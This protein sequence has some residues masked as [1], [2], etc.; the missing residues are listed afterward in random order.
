MSRGKVRKRIN[1]GII[2]RTNVT[3]L[4]YTLEFLSKGWNGAKI[5]DLERVI[6]KLA[7][8]IQIYAPLP[9]WPHTDNNDSKQTGILCAHFTSTGSRKQALFSCWHHF[10]FEIISNVYLCFGNNSITLFFWLML[11]YFAMLLIIK[12]IKGKIWFVK[13]YFK[14][15]WMSQYG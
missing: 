11:I 12:V 1:S 5:S 9:W 14:E 15:V 7:R 3:F 6:R 4:L 2:L 8:G 13:K 10:W